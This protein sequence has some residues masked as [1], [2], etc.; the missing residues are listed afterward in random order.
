MDHCL[1]HKYPSSLSLLQSSLPPKLNPSRV[2]PFNF[3]G[4]ITRRINFGGRT[5]SPYR[6]GF[7]VLA[8][9]GTGSECGEYRGLYTPVQ[10]TTPAGRL[11]GTVLLNDPDYFPQVVQ[12]QLEQLAVD[13]YE[14]LLRMNLSSASHEACLHRRIAELK[15]H[16]CQAAIEDA[17]YVVICSKFYEIR[18]HLVPQL[19]KCMYN[20]RLEIQPSKDWELESIHSFEVLEMIREHLTTFVGWRANSSV[21]DK[22]AVTQISRLQ[23]CQVYTASVLYGYFLKAASLR[24]TL[25]KNLLHMNFDLGLNVGSH[26][27]VADMWALGSKAAMFGRVLSTRSTSVSEVSSNQANK[28]DKLRCYVMGFDPESLQMCAKPKSKEAANLI[29]RQS[30][31]LFGDEETGLLETNEV[32]STSFASLKRYVLEAIAFGSYLWDAEEYISTICE[33]ED[34]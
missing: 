26:F 30:F 15:E 9:S 29:E 21:T 28:G 34:N 8:A 32:I 6:R 17:M 13:R 16:E 25:E 3:A 7:L 18:V 12:K 19:S 33:L 11:L 31:A 14:A 22:W 10:P 24:H 4:N 5:R 1:A 20:G 23:L 2:S 27:P